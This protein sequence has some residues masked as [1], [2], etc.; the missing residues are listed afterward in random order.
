MTIRIW[1]QRNGHERVRTQIDDVMAELRAAGSKERR[2]WGDILCGGRD[3]KELT[4]A[5][6]LFPVL[7]AAQ[8]S[9]RKAVTPNAIWS[10]EEHEDFPSVRATGRWAK[11]RRLP[12]R[13]KKIHKQNVVR[14]LR[15]S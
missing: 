15:A 14:H 12:R 7:R 5:G 8:I 1:L 13:A 10:N 11:S 2:N 4:V 9:R 6:R 3:G